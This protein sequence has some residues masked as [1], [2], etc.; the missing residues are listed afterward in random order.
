[1]DDM[2]STPEQARPE[3]SN[4]VPLNQGKSMRQTY[5][6]EL[7][8]IVSQLI[9]MNN[10][11]RIAVKDSTRALLE[12]DAARA[13]RVVEKDKLL[14]AQQEELEDRCFNL[15]ARQAPVAGE[16]RT[17]VSA[18]R[19]ANE[20]ARMGDLSAHVAK[21]A[22]LRAP[23]PAVPQPLVASFQRMS[24]VA[25]EMI[26]VAG[27]T[28]TDRDIAEASQLA[29][30]DEEMDELRR[31]QF[32]VLLGGEWD[33]GVESAVDVALLGRYYERIA[34]HAVSMARRIIYVITGT[35]PEGENWPT[36]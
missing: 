1:M 28:L 12:A 15:L 10:H 4:D 8:D 26:L 11:V 25:D 30:A 32:T 35:A 14:D 2:M 34:D 23:E 27:Q 36:A 29:E 7:D 6:A 16:L 19:M 17:V 9:A 31:A 22:V 5:H 21:I 33:H 3:P 24:E 18:M 20:L 13:Q